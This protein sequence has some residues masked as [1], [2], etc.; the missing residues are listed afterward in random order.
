S[1]PPQEETAVSLLT[2]VGAR[3]GLRVIGKTGEAT[4]YEPTQFER[5]VESQSTSVEIIEPAFVYTDEGNEVVIE[6]GMV[7]DHE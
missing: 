2:D 5:I 4:V 7:R 3:F 6:K 1:L